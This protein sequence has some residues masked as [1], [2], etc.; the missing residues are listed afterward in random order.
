MKRRIISAG[1]GALSCYDSAVAFYDSEL[2]GRMDTDLNCKAKSSNM[3]R[4]GHM[5][6]ISTAKPI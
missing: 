4:R 3:E 1:H 6:Y 5:P 2:A